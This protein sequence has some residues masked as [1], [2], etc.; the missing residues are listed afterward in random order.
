MRNK[1][2]HHTAALAAYDEAGLV[3]R[4]PRDE[5]LQASQTEGRP[6]ADDGDVAVLPMKVRSQE[7]WWHEKSG[8]GDLGLRG[9]R[10]AP[11]AQGGALVPIACFAAGR[12]KGAGVLKH[13]GPRLTCVKPPAMD[14]R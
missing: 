1:K 7:R 10:S 9:N 8:R 14:R 6:Q 11:G 5:P 3:D 4:D 12:D 13:L 2:P